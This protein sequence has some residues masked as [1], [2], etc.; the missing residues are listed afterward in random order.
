[1]VSVRLERLPPPPLPVGMLITADVCIVRLPRLVGTATFHINHPSVALPDAPRT[2]YFKIEA[3][4]TG[5]GSVVRQRK[6][7]AALRLQLCHHDITQR[8]FHIGRAAQITDTLQQSGRFGGKRC[9]ALETVGTPDTRYQAK[10]SQAVRGIKVAVLFLVEP[11]PPDAFRL[12]AVAQRP[13]IV[14]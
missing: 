1:M 8:D 4:R 2:L 6:Q 3:A 11:A 7:Y 10:R 5:Q 12:T 14:Q 9:Q 13:V